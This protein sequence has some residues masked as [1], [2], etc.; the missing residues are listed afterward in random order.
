MTE[1]YAV[2]SPSKMV[3]DNLSI[4]SGKTDILE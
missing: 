4:V 3:V 1:G 2:G